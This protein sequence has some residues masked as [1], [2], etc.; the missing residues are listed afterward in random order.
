M[1]YYRI[2]AIR[3]S[4]RGKASE[5]DLTLR[6]PTDFLI[7]MDGEVRPLQSALSITKKR[8]IARKPDEKFV[9]QTYYAA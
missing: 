8:D 2:F 6:P 9:R 5:N 1:S 4:C 3:N 7:T